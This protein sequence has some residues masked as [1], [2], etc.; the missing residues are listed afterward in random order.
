[1]VNGLLPKYKGDSPKDPKRKPTQ[2]ELDAANAQAKDIARRSNAHGVDPE[3]THVGNELPPTVYKGKEYPY[4]Y[5]IPELANRNKTYKPIPKDATDAYMADDGK[6]YF[7]DPHTGNS[8]EMHPFNISL[9]QFSEAASKD[10]AI[11]AALQKR[12]A[13]MAGTAMQGL[14]PNTL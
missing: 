10:P 12:K 1:M 13:M 4:G 14:L 9:P 2:A 11:Q 5:Q 8:E 3:E 7:V 6:Y